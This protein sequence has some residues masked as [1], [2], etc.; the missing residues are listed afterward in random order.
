MSR[1]L[2]TREDW[3]IKMVMEYMEFFLEF[4]KAHKRYMRKLTKL[5]KFINNKEY[6]IDD[7]MQVNEICS[8][9]NEV[10]ELLC[11]YNMGNIGQFAN[12]VNGMQEEYKD[13]SKHIDRFSKFFKMMQ[14]EVGKYRPYVEY[15][16]YDDEDE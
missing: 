10:G 6:H 8:A 16:N 4:Q 1:P 3:F 2:V 12:E 5:E 11:D 15:D 7:F 14:R 13:K 9:E